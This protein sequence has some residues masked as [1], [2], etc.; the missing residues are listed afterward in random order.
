[1]KKG[2]EQIFHCFDRD[3][4]LMGTLKH[5]SELRNEF[6]STGSVDFVPTPIH[7]E[8]FNFIH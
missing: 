8:K 1:V 3:D 2:A 4:S 5:V 7:N 6:G